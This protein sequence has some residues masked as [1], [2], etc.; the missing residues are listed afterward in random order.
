MA[1]PP[2][3]DRSNAPRAPHSP[4]PR[5][6]SWLF[7]LGLAA[8]ACTTRPTGTAPHDMSAEQH[9]REAASHERVAEAHAEQGE[10]QALAA[11]PNC[12][13]PQATEAAGVCW[14]SVANATAEHRQAA[15]AHR[16]EAARHRAASAALRD[17]EA[18][19]CVGIAEHDRDMSPFEHVEDIAAVEPLEEAVSGGPKGSVLMR[20]AGAVVTF[21]AVPGLTPEWLQRLIDCHLARN[22]SRGHVVPEMPNCPLVPKG[23]AATVRSTGDGFAVS[24]SSSDDATAR[25]I[26]ARAERLH[27]TRG[28]EPAK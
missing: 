26:L 6:T 8:V 3:L 20:T 21:R 23:A 16:A 14:S 10:A 27:G 28:P 24:I 13:P 15:E 5:P 22:A 7:G 19:T 1:P 2:P 18:R 9:N 25:E 12:A 17:A 11:R 4:Q